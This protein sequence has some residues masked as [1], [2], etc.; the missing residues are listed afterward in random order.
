MPRSRSA[1]RLA[2]VLLIL[3]LLSSPLVYYLLKFRATRGLAVLR[4]VSETT[5]DEA[6]GEKRHMSIQIAPLPSSRFR[7]YSV[8]LGFEISD[9]AHPE[10]HIDGFF[11]PYPS[12]VPLDTCAVRESGED[13]SYNLVVQLGTRDDT[14]TAIQWCQGKEVVEPY[15]REFI[16]RF[17][18]EPN[19]F[20]PVEQ[21]RLFGGYFWGVVLRRL[22]P[23]S[24]P[25]P[26]EFP[27]LAMLFMYVVGLPLVVVHLVTL[28]Y[29]PLIVVIPPVLSIPF[30]FVW[31]LSLILLTIDYFH[32]FRMTRNLWKRVK[33]RLTR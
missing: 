13:N 1:K 6:G 28:I 21:L 24:L 18:S 8:Y 12:A 22:N 26:G 15:V 2:L 30:F 29:L 17:Q 25:M 19:S 3:S 14:G 20:S 7:V 4:T 11:C 16:S 5:I 33:S 32:S 27:F 10:V 31:F 9:D 23:S